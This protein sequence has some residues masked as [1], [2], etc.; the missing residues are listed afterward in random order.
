MSS[1]G[2]QTRERLLHA[3]H[4]LVMRQGFAATTV[5]A[6]LEAAPATKGG[7]FHHFPSKAA[8]GDALVH[9]YAERDSAHLAEIARRAERLGADPVHRVLVFVELLAEEAEGLTRPGNGCLFAAFLYEQ[10]LIQPESRRVIAASMQ[11]WRER[12]GAMLAEAAAARPT[13]PDA[14]VRVL[15]D[16]LLVTLEG[17]FVLS[18]AFDD[19]SVVAEQLRLY[20]AQ[21]ESLLA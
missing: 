7:F 17:A 12:F 16:A 13:V 1:R 6:V 10:E 21:L 19:P 20:R 2:A 18:R 14:D 8:L 5:D 4:D 15:A 11:A 9:R 3:A